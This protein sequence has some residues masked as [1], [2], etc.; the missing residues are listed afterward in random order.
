VEHRG[1]QETERDILFA[2]DNEDPD[3]DFMHNDVSLSNCIVNDDKIV[4]LVDWEMAGF[5][6]WE[7][8]AKVHVQI[9]TPR[10]ENFASLDLPEEMLRIFSFGM[11]S[12]SG[13]RM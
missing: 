8:A 13:S 12:M 4:G 11:I 9:R 6:D 1:I 3:V 2:K 7:T 10:R 5:F